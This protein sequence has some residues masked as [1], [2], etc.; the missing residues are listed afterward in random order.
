MIS[1][2]LTVTTVCLLFSGLIMI[3]NASEDATLEIERTISMPN[4]RLSG[5]TG[6]VGRWN[7]DE[8][9]GTTA[10]D[11]SGNNNNGSLKNMDKNTSWVKGITTTGSALSFDGEDDYV[12]I[13]HSSSLNINGNVTI[14]V[15]AKPNDEP[16]LSTQ[17]PSGTPIYNVSGLQA[18]KND[19]NGTYYLSNDIDAKETFDWNEEKGFEPIGMDISVVEGY[20]G[21]PFNGTFDGRGYTISN[22]QINRDHSDYIGLFGNITSS[23]Q[24]RNVTLNSVKIIGWNYTGGLVGWNHGGSLV[25]CSVN[26][27][28]SNDE[29]VTVDMPFYIGGLVGMNFGGSITDCSTSGNFDGLQYSGGLVGG[30]SGDIINS[31]SK[32]TMSP[33]PGP[34]PVPGGSHCGGLVGHNSDSGTIT[35]CYTEVDIVGLGYFGGLVGWNDGSIKDSYSKGKLVGQYY[36]A[37]FGSIGFDAGGLV[38]YNTGSIKACYATTSV[39]GASSFTGMGGLVGTNWGGS[40][41]SCYSTGNL[42]GMHLLGG[43]V[44]MH[45]SGTISECYST[46]DLTFGT[47]AITQSIGGLIGHVGSGIITSCYSTGNNAELVV[48]STS[49]CGG[50]F[51]SIDGG[52]VSKCY[53]TGSSTCSGTSGGSVGIYNGGTFTGC[54]WDTQTSGTSTAIGSGSTTGI[55]GKTT[56]EMKQRSTFTTSS[57]DFSNIWYLDDGSSYPNIAMFDVVVSKGMDAYALVIEPVGGSLFGFIGGEFVTTPL[58]DKD[59]WYHL[60]LT[61]DGENISLF[62]NSTLTA[63]GI[64]ANDIG[65]NALELRFGGGTRQYEG[66]LDEARIW[67]RNLSSPEIVDS[68]HH[69][70]E[71]ITQ[72]VTSV[73]EDQSYHI[74]YTAFDVNGDA[75][76]W[77]LRSNASWLSI[78]P[79][80]GI[81]EGSPSNE[82]VGHHC[83]NVSVDDGHKGK[84]WHNF[85]LTVDNVNDAPRIITEADTDVFDGMTYQVEFKA[86][87][88]D[89]TM[90]ILTWKIT[91][92]ASWLR[93]N[94][95]TGVLNGTPTNVDVGVFYANISVE[96]GN[97]GQD[98]LNY[99][100]T[101]LNINDAPIILTPNVPTAIEDQ[102]YSVDYE[103]VDPDPTN[104]ILVWSLTTN[105]NW[106]NIN[107]STGVLNGTPT[108][109]DVG[110]HIVIVTVS[111]QIGGVTTSEFI[112][113]VTNV[114]DA[115][116]W[117]ET[118]SDQNITEG[119]WIYLAVE[120]EDVDL[121]DMITYSITS[122]PIINISINKTNGRILW[123]QTLPG[124]HIVNVSASDGIASIYHKFSISVN[125]L[126]I[127]PEENDTEPDNQTKPDDNQTRPDDNQTIA[128]PGPNATTDTDGDGIPDW[129]EDFYGFD[130]N[131][132]SDAAQDPD[133]DDITNLEEYN[134]RTN[135][136]KSDKVT[137]NGTDGG[138]TDGGSTDGG[139]GNGTDGGEDGGGTESTD[140]AGFYFIIILLFVLLI[141]MAGVAGYFMMKNSGDN[142]EDLGDSTLEEELEEDE[143][144]EEVLEQEDKPEE[145]E[146]P[147][148]EEEPNEDIEEEELDEEEPEEDVEDEEYEEEEL[149]E[150]ELEEE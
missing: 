132:A 119:E 130:P 18:M 53:S 42:N 8:G 61:F 29:T 131:N 86:I 94:E 127:E 5:A 1:K 95:T 58:P 3:S 107:Q 20:Q 65:Q 22:L 66:R 78:D 116:T 48:S 70:P 96:D 136:L 55:T 128:E 141:A 2:T 103:A 67:S 104:D 117:T 59:S 33:G 71:I 82:D 150:E 54:Y 115:P 50:L 47:V 80:N 100:L 112:L 102:H 7:L 110:S 101:V 98:W 10:L 40:I 129:W 121:G 62:I 39:W 30:N 108:N 19:L 31:Y 63:K 85:T 41:H 140:T 12:S 83:V 68:Y 52:T 137:T 13:P 36:V 17:Q 90:D 44:G 139:D 114:N 124:D 64:S 46:G 125:A 45:Y 16:Y 97:G 133:D 105:A 49:G 148:E 26:G 77:S 135:P 79:S 21:T 43:L 6:L 120:A 25:N 9:N 15:W 69:P 149:D 11:S 74:T 57:W 145:E 72:D 23:A 92:N 147:D 106:L 142:D 99:A 91:T 81:L 76:T 75:L 93:L 34:A 38:G 144:E 134:G 60:A 14:E 73:L 37:P 84:D 32:P 111:D 143:P 146:F 89:P 113:N 35:E 28:A 51:G 118:P 4:T 122:T 27:L 109:D 126:P 87:D 56:T 138:S 123:K 24:I 88:I